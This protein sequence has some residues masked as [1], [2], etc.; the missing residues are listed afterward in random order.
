MGLQYF[1]HWDQQ[2]RR[3]DIGRCFPFN[4]RPERRCSNV[5]AAMLAHLRETSNKLP[6]L[7]E[8]LM[9]LSLQKATM[10]EEIKGRPAIG[11]AV[12]DK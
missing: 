8:N 9:D 2:L 7:G 6:V 5:T 3:V 12:V 4:L 11:P 10:S 1:S